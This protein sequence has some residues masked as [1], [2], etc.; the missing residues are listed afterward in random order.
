MTAITLPNAQKQ[1][2][3]H[4]T[5]SAV[6][7]KVRTLPQSGEDAAS[8]QLSLEE[9]TPLKLLGRSLVTFLPRLSLSSSYHS[10]SGWERYDDLIPLPRDQST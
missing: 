6:D 5:S 10:V 1:E 3:P 9:E 7:I 2:Y 4:V 8:L